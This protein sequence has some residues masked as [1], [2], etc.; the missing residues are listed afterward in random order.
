M[1]VGRVFVNNEV[2]RLSGRTDI[3]PMPESVLTKNPPKDDTEMKEVCCR[4]ES[5]YQMLLPTVWF[6]RRRRAKESDNVSS[7]PQ[8]TGIETSLAVFEWENLNLFFRSSLLWTRQNKVLTTA[9]HPV[10]S[11]ADLVEGTRGTE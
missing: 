10:V 6:A 5:E 3:V 11:D 1:G 9:A 8:S 2:A 4:H 7:L